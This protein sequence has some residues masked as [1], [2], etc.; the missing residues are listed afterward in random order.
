MAR[1]QLQLPKIDYSQGF[2]FPPLANT[3]AGFTDLLPEP[4]QKFKFFRFG[5]QRDNPFHCFVD[6]WR[7]EAIW[8]HADKYIDSLILSSLAIAPD[9]TVET[10]Y[11]LPYAFY[12]VW[13][14]RVVA[15]WWASHGLFTIPVLQWSRPEINHHLFSGLDHCQVVAVRS[16]TKGYNDQWRLGAEQFLAIHRPQ[17]VLH[18]GTKAGIGVWPNAINLNLR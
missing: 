7:L 3:L 15:A 8:R 13:R 12:Q 16:P 6:D 18:F 10:N 14:S 2:A 17:L 9:F 5:T 1:F 4:D 11:P